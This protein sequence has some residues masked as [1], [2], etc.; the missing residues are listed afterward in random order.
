MC[1]LDFFFLFFF[2]RG[3][4]LLGE[5]KRVDRDFSIE[6]ERDGSEDGRIGRTYSV[7]RYLPQRYD[8]FTIGRPTNFY[9][10]IGEPGDRAL[11]PPRQRLRAGF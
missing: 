4:F 5:N 7:A 11:P 1:V 2:I 3:I 9:F 10:A 8:I 6:S